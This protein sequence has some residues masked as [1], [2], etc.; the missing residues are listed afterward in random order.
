MMPEQ[1]HAR[2]LERNSPLDGNLPE[3]L[4]QGEQDPFFGLGQ[5]QKE[6]V[7]P[8]AAIRP[9]PQNIM[10]SGAQQIHSRLGKVFV[11]E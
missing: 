1:Y 8:S 4:V 2:A 6:R 3:V 11:G 10:A 5:F 7:F 9:G